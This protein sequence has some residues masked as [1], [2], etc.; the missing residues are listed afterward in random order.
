[1]VA[2]RVAITLYLMNCTHYDLCIGIRLAH[3]DIRALGLLPQLACL[4][5]RAL[6]GIY[7]V[8]YGFVVS[9]C[10]TVCLTLKI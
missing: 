9:A 3:A 6:A 2:I 10:V 5:V 7:V 8:P 4:R 1:M